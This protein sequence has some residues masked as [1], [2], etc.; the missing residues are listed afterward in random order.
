MQGR[1]PEFR[2]VTSLALYGLQP[3]V[4]PCEPAFQAHSREWRLDAQPPTSPHSPPSHNCPLPAA[5]GPACFFDAYL[6][7]SALAAAHGP[8]FG[9]RQRKPPRWMTALL[10]TLLAAPRALGDAAAPSRTALAERL[11][12]S[13]AEGST[14]VAP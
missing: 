9:M 3:L 6:K 1:A 10:A 7:P 11:G 13:E 8:L 12:G 4:P 5:R 2:A 14:M